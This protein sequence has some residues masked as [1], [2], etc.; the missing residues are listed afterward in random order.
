MNVLLLTSA[1]PLCD[2][3][4]DT[5]HGSLDLVTFN[6]HE[7]ASPVKNNKLQNPPGKKKKQV[8]I[9]KKPAR[10]TMIIL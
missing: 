9:L 8:F 1:I 4:R 6:V 7:R 5:D 2:L 10:I 3:S